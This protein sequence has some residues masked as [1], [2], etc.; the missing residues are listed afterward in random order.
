[1]ASSLPRGSVAAADAASDDCL[2]AAADIDGAGG[3]AADD[4]LDGL[5]DGAAADDCLDGLDDGAADDDDIDGAI[6][7]A[8]DA[9]DCPY[10]S[11]LI[12]EVAARFGRGRLCRFG[13][14]EPRL[15]HIIAAARRCC[16]FARLGRNLCRR[17][18][19]V[20][21]LSGDLQQGAGY[22]RD[23]REV[24]I[25]RAVAGGHD[26]QEV[27][28]A[29]NRFRSAPAVRAAADRAVFA[30]ELRRQFS[31]VECCARCVRYLHG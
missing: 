2:E 16:R 5:D 30:A 26:R 3:A 29:V 31:R 10:A 8:D 7:A 6:A 17:I 23:K 11:A 12:A 13:L 14:M 25:G 22:I 19:A 24:I 9:D 21:G 20:A 18:L 15:R 28:E 1:M 27:I 4:C